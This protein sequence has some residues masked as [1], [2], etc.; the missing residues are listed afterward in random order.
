[1]ASTTNK[2]QAFNQLL[3]AL[4]K[5]CDPADP[6]KRPVLETL[7]YGILREGATRALA[8]DAFLKLKS[9]FFDWN[10]IR[11]STPQ[12]VSEVLTTLP[13]AEM[14]AQRIVAV[15][16]E[17]FETNYSFSLDDIDKKGLKQAAK[18]LSRLHEVT[19]YAIAWVVQQALGG[20]AIGLDSPTIR[21]IKRLG[22]A[23]DEDNPEHLRT[24]LEH[25]VPKAKGALFV[26]AISQIAA[27]YCA[28]ND[29]AC[30]NCPL[31]ADCP[32]G[33]D[34]GPAEGTRRPKPR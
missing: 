28:E 7:I 5:H 33:Q 27:D 1:M 20:H 14:K 26:E 9:S 17:V 24:S 30:G 25:Y 18:Q 4:K 21:V 22:L 6:E 13:D 34:R 19:D 3:A 10:E 11:V 8:D 32:T 31:R 2:P 15:L 12:E 23:E 29:P 16:Q